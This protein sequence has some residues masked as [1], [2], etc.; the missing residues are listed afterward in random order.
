MN[1]S[2]NYSELAGAYGDRPPYPDDAIDTLLE[3]TGMQPGGY[4]CDIGAGTGHLT[5]PLAARGFRIDA[6][7]PNEEMRRIGRV[8]TEAAGTTNWYEARGEAT[9]RPADRYHLVTFGSSFNVVDRAAALVETARI[10]RSGGWFSCMWNHRDLDDPL[11]AEIEMLVR[12]RITGYSYGSR[13]ADQI[14][15]IRSSGL[16]EEPSSFDLHH[17]HSVSTVS[18]LN[19][20]RS[21]ATLARQAGSEFETIVDEIG[22]IIGDEQP[23][24]DIPYTTRVYIARLRDA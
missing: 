22:A 9:E 7:E 2:W 19:A 10:L 12:R 4:I 17:V 14:P 11:Q 21:H 23:T 1:V 16:F 15:V 8:R 13:R 3:M 5:E 20:W 24:L 18:W 6:V